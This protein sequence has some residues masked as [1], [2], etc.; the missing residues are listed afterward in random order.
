MTI[1]LGGGITELEAEE[2]V[3]GTALFKKLVVDQVQGRG[4]R[5]E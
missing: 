3:K 2:A 4:I 5:L 1:I